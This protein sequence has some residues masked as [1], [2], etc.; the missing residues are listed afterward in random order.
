MLTRAPLDLRAN[1]IKA[2]DDDLATLFPEGEAIPGAA[3]GWRL[4]PETAAIQHPAYA[5]GR[6]EVQDAAS[7]YAS[8]AL[9]AELGHAIVDRS[10]E[11]TSEL[12]SLMRISYAVFCLKKKKNKPPNQPQS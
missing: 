2:G 5:E 12:Q 4:P 10:E 7:Q 11:H 6:F 8:A 9:G 1:R 3:D